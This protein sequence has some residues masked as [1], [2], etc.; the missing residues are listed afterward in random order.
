MWSKI[1]KGALGGLLAG[2]VFGIMMQMMDAP[3]PEGTHV[4]M[5]MMVAMVVNS[6][7]LFIGWLYHLFNSAVIGAIFGWMLGGR[8]TNYARGTRLGLMYGFAWWI[9]GGLVLMPLLLGMP[10]F[11]PMTME[12]MRPVALGSLMGHV[13]YGVILGATY[14]W[15]THYR[16]ETPTV[17]RPLGV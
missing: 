6:T 7:S 13:F 11:A 3:T 12:P 2:L 5:M 9:I 17:E 14:V 10:T 1:K 15:L 8:S 4:P 16:H